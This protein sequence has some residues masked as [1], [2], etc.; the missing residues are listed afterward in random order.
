VS[1]R[2]CIYEGL[3]RPLTEGLE[4]EDAHGREV[5]FDPGFSAGVERFTTRG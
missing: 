3:G 4:L 5:I 2:Q 1:D